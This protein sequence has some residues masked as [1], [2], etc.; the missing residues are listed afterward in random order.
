MGKRNLSSDFCS[1]AWVKLTKPFPA[2]DQARG[3]GVWLGTL[4]PHVL[5]Y[6]QLRGSALYELGKLRLEVSPRSGSKDM[7]DAL[8]VWLDLTDRAPRIALHR[9]QLVKTGCLLSWILGY[10]NDESLSD[11]PRA[12]EL[13]Q[14]AVDAAPDRAECW[15]ALAAARL[16]AGTPRERSSR[17]PGRTVCTLSPRKQSFSCLRLL[18]ADS[19]TTITPSRTVSMPTS[20]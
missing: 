7:E 12:L 5:R 1:I 8:A 20:C 17:S 16:C 4:F 11:P 6:N 18:A 3:I 10:A 15:T 9:E 14:Q 13:A 19:R 2:L